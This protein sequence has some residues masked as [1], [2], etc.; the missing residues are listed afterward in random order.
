L[1]LFFL[2]KIARF[3]PSKHAFA[4]GAFYSDWQNKIFLL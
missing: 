4:G 3:I 1:I 2:I